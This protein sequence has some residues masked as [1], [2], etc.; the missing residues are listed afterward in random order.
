ML[1]TAYQLKDLSVILT[2]GH[3]QGRED[4]VLDQWRA[5]LEADPITDESPVALEKVGEA[6]VREGIGHVVDAFEIKYDG[7]ATLQGR[8]DF[9]GAETHGDVAIREEC[10]VEAR[11][12]LDGR[13]H[14]FNY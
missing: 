9:L 12:H 3:G 2:V 1:L 7:L 10:R 14:V 4:E 11:A 8:L 13:K 5:G 6:G